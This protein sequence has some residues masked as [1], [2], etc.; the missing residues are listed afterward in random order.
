MTPPSN[1]PLFAA[2]WRKPVDLA[3]ASRLVGHGPTVMVGALHD[4]RRNLMAAAWS[5]PVE[6]TPPRIAIVLDK[7]TWTRELVV[8]SGMLSLMVPCRASADL[9]YT[10]GS[11]GGR[12]LAAEGDDK[13]RRYGIDTFDGPAL[14]LPFATDCIAWL[15]CSLLR[16]PGVDE[17][18]DTFFCE[19]VSASADTRVFSDGHW[20]LD[21]APPDLHTLHYIAAG[22]FAVGSTTVR[23]TMLTDLNPADDASRGSP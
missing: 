19:V 3:H 14:G 17:R 7:S 22:S 2:H 4:G 5:M 13:F 23:A 8:A 11:V 10:V 1:H 15:E 18:Y 16:E 20:T 6:F 12:K 9:T 21:G